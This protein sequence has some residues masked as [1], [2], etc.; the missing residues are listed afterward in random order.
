MNGWGMGGDEWVDGWGI[1]EDGWVRDGQ[2]SW[3][4]Y[5]ID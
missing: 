4:M 5:A 1:E 2:M 3:G